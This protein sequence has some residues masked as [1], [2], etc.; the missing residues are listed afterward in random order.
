VR[1][2]YIVG[3]S[4]ALARFLKASIEGNYL[5]LTDASRAKQ[6]LAKELKITDQKVLEVT[7]SDFKAQ[8]PA[9]LEL[10]MEGA[11]NILT[12]F[13][14]DQNVAGYVDTSLLDALRSEGFFSAMAQKYKQ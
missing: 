5:A 4:D 9:N 7:Y 6:V 2:S 10:S 14:G 13:G 12:Q 8:S 11:K 1:R 3:R